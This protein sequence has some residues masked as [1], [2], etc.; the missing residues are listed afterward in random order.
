MKYKSLILFATL[1]FSSLSSLLAQDDN[2]PT[3]ILVLTDVVYP[4]KADQYEKAQKDMNVF[5]AKN[6]PSLKW[7][8]I[9]F[10]QYAYNYIVDIKDYSAIDEWDKGW[11]EKMKTIDQT[12]FKKL[13]SAFDGTI[14]K[15]R[16]SAYSSNENGRYK[17]KE[18]FVDPKDAN[19]L[20][21]DY[22]EFIPGKED[23]AIN[24]S[25]EMI[26]LNTQ[27]NSKMSSRLWREEWG[28]NTNS[29]LV[30]RSDKNAPDFYSDMEK[31]NQLG[32]D[33]RK[34]IGNKF[35][36]YV[37]KFEHWNGKVRDDLSISDMTTANK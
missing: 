36:S 34:E 7:T 20:H 10:D 24:V 19:F 25:H 3:R 26:A 14:I 32:G 35:M 12:E 15:T 6:F 4:Y 33:K 13:S 17:A 30:V 37:Q 16:Q 1:L 23:D 11:Q 21:F 2:K 9:Q 22:Y 27:L 28:E 8:C 31:T 29:I 5:L 18:P